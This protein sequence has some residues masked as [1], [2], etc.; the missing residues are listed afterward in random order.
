MASDIY[1]FIAGIKMRGNAEV[2]I[3]QGRQ[4]SRFPKIARPW[5]AAE[6][7]GYTF[8]FL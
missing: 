2:S 6:L 5:L 8:I 3:R 7:T 1:M 4:E